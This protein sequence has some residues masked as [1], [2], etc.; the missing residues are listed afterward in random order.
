MFLSTDDIGTDESSVTDALDSSTNLTSDASPAPKTPTFGEIITDPGGGIVE[1]QIDD[2]GTEYDE[3]PVIII[4][5][6]G[7]GAASF[8]VVR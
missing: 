3:P 2:P 6:E 5:G 1:I 4:T 8:T 7:N